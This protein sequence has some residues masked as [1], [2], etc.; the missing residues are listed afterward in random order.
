MTA[1]L[2]SGLR[3]EPL[4][5]RLL[6]N[7]KWIFSAQVA[8]A[9][10][11]MVYLA[12]GARALGAAGLGLIAV[13]EAYSRIMARLLHLEPWQ[14]VI[15]HASTALENDEVDR[16]GRLIGLSVLVDLAGGVLAATVAFF[17]APILAPLLGL[18]DTYYWLLPVGAAACVLSLRATGISLLRIY[19]RFDI[20]A[21][22][23]SATAAF[24]AFLAIMA[25]AFDLGL[26]GFAAIFVLI[27]LLDG[28]LAYLV[29][30]TQMRKRGHRLQFGGIRETLAENP[31]FLRFMWNSN[32]SVILR[33]TSQRL[34][35]IILAAMVPATA[36][37]YYHIAR[38]CGDAALR[39]GRPLSQ[40]IYPEF[41]RLS[42]RGQVAKLGKILRNISAGFAVV[43]VLVL[44]PVIWQL[45]KII[46]AFFGPEFGPAVPVVAIQAVAVGFY[47]FGCIVNPALLSLEQDRAMV[48]IGALITGLFF[49]VIY[50]M[51]TTFGV[52]GAAASHLICNAIWLVLCSI[53]LKRAVSAAVNKGVPRE[54]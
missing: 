30:L 27:S 14:A 9:L 19:D 32:L 42:A 54:S 5:K 11:G 10:L 13:L 46:L 22:L 35:V 17:L 50:P 40:T 33:Q 53:V 29:G 43:L 47:L 48:R 3:D 18:E 12:F 16:F 26:V 24:R 45:D 37:G 15:R 44:T 38:R 8:V 7:L 20:L 21:K 51:V 31:G 6:R 41:T 28:T 52:A 1:R 39:L 23:D 49:V 2:S 4:K 36:V 34:D 25:W